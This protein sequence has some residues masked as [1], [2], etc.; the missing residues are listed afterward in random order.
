[1]IMEELIINKYKVKTIE[2]ALRLAMNV[3]DSRNKAKETA[4]DR[5]LLLANK[6]IKEV[7]ATSKNGK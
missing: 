3:L 2:N 7:L 5:E 6:Y 1:M 4:M